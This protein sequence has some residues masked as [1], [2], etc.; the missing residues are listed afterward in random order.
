M[1][2]GFALGNFLVRAAANHAV[3]KQAEQEEREE[4]EIVERVEQLTGDLNQQFALRKSGEYSSNAFL[5]ILR[6]RVG[7]TTSLR[8]EFVEKLRIEIREDLKRHP[9][10]RKILKA[11]KDDVPIF[12]RHPELLSEL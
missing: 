4:A 5:E 12:Q 2:A 10:L 8:P 7:D 3:R 6:D 9:E 11:L 1:N